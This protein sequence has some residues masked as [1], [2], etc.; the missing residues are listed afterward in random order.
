M[1]ITVLKEVNLSASAPLGGFLI[2]ENRL[3]LFYKCTFRQC[4][5]S[6][7]S[8]VQCTLYNCTF[9][10]NVEIWRQSGK[11]NCEVFT[12]YIFW[13]NIRCFLLKCNEIFFAQ[14]TLPGPQ[15]TRLKRFSELLRSRRYFIKSSKMKDCRQAI[16][17]QNVAVGM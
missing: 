2:C 13:L 7:K 4:S 3:P 15:M 12:V 10:M 11:I 5:D 9:Q 17:A 16:L 6:I 1:A 14:K 8:S